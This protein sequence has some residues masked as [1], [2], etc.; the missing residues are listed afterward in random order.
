MFRRARRP[1]DQIQRA[2]FQHIRMRGVPGLVAI[3]VPMGGFRKPVEA[4]IMKGLGAAKGTPDV[5]LWHA[6]KSYALELKAEGGRLTESQADFL[7]KLADAGTVTAVA[8]GIDYAIK[9]LEDWGLL[10]GH[11]S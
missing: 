6:G 3:H 2:L 7:R 8:H 1:E 5:L 11:A 10:R 4:A 9:Q